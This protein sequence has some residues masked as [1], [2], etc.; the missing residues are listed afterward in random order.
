LQG[1]SEGYYTFPCPAL[2]EVGFQ[3]GGQNYMMNVAD[4]I[5]TQS[6]GTCLGALVGADEADDTETTLVFILGALFLKNVMTVFDLG[7]PA[8]GFGRLKDADT[9][10]GSYTIVP[11][12]QMTALGTGPFASLSPT[13]TIPPRIMTLYN[14]LQQSK[15]Q[16][17]YSRQR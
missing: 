3:L 17:I 16:S 6:G 9:Q 5:L 13:L 1:D 10:Y 8:V 14:Y 11:Q 4:F 15:I 7:A 2:S 12:N